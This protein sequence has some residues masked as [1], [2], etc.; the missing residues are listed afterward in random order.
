[1]AERYVV[2]GGSMSEPFFHSKDG[3][4]SIEFR[5]AYLWKNL[6]LAQSC[7]RELSERLKEPVRSLS[8]WRVERLSD[9]QEWYE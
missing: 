5:D 7:V 2:M 3:W 1:M 6:P 9:I 8:N 4:V